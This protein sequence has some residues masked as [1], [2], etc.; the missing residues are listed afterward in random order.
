MSYRILG[1]DPVEDQLN[2]VLE[3]L[4]QGQPPS[5]IEL[6]Q[7]DVKE[8]LGRR[9][10]G[11]AILPATSK[12]EAAAQYLV[13]EMA[14][15]ANTPGGGAI[16]LGVADN[17][18]RIGTDLDADWL[19]HRIWEMSEHKLTVT[20]REA[21]LDSTRILI[22]T[23][24]EAIEPIRVAGKL[25][26]RVDTNC[27][28][29]DATSWH[30]G[31]MLRSG[32]DWS[33]QPSGHTVADA[34]AVAIE[35]AR[36]YLRSAG[37]PSS[38]DLAASSN[39]DM[40]TR[41]SLVDSKGRLS[42]AGSLLFVGTPQIGIDYIRRQVSAGDSTNRVRGNG[43]LLEQLYEV[44]NASNS[45]NR[46]VHRRDGFASGQLRAIPS[47][48]LREAI[49]NGIVHRDWLS[50]EPTT[51]EHIG[52]ELVV[53]SPGGFIGGVRPSNIITHPSVPRY[54]SLAEAMATLRLAE[55]EGI[56]VDRMI[57]DML[58]LGHAEPSIAETPGPYI[59]VALLGG[60]PSESITGFLRQVVPSIIGGDLDAL[61][62]ISHL[63][64]LGWVD[65]Y[66]AARILQRPAE[67]TK[68]VLAR[69]TEAE[70]L[71][72]P[73]LTRMKGVPA[74]QPFAYRLG[75]GSRRCLGGAVQA[76]AMSHHQRV[77]YW[78]TNRSRVSS[79]EAAELTDLSQVTAGRLLANLASDGLLRPGRATHGRGFFYVPVAANDRANVDPPEMEGSP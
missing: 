77:L 8:E 9:G 76:T 39:N 69:L 70:F 57:R 44:D 28:E 68:A 52:D 13:A 3:L 37:D 61:L 18:E 2:R 27:V 34:Q 72:D 32:F 6:A 19:R 62:V 14:C 49:V 5:A 58:A 17:G 66:S 11:G 43:P 36:R 15:L 56:G 78:S 64:R 29:I 1:P 24:H 67:E 25:K 33:T 51:V 60:D 53:T 73:V 4:S 59:R 22:L 10:R 50:P 79:A 7:V 23:T 55:R 74:G 65:E 16:I 40:L 21:E 47:R 54:R 35:I 41:L 20:I 46:L 38:L 26:W 71:G 48:A 75:L 45:N 31:K 42:N 12:N 63:I 30:T